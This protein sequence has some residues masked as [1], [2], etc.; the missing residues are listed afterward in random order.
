MSQ[1]VG[2]IGIGSPEMLDYLLHEEFRFVR[3]DKVRLSIPKL[4]RVGGLFLASVFGDYPK[5]IH[6]RIVADQHF[7]KFIA[8]PECLLE[9]YLDLMHE[10]EQFPRRLTGFYLDSPRKSSFVL[11]VDATKPNDLIDYWNLRAAGYIVL[12]IATQV[13][14]QPEILAHVA[15]FVDKNA[16]AEPMRNYMQAV[17]FMGARSIAHARV[18]EFLRTLELPPSD[19]AGRPR[20]ALALTYPRLWD[21]WA[22]DMADEGPQLPFGASQEAPV[23]NE[24]LEVEVNSVKPKFL[25]EDVM[26]GGQRYAN[27]VEVRVYKSTDPIAEV[28]PEGPRS[29]TQAFGSSALFSEWRLSKNGA[30]FFGAWSRDQVRI[31]GPNAEALMLSWLEHHGWKAELSP[32]G[33][34]AKQMLKQLNG[35]GGLHILCRQRLIELLHDVNKTGWMADATFRGRI[36]ELLRRENLRWSA[37]EYIQELASAGIIRLGIETQCLTCMRRNWYALDQL[38]Y[39]VGCSHC[40]AEFP[41]PA[42]DVD[43]LSWSY[44]TQGPFA[45]PDQAAGAYAVLL[46]LQF[47]QGDWGNGTSPLLSYSAQRGDKKMEADLTLLFRENRYSRADRISVIHAECKS[48]HSFESKDVQRMRA[49]GSHFPGAYLVFSKLGAY[50]DKERALIVPTAEK[51]RAQRFRSRQGNPVIVLSGVELFSWRGWPR[52]WEGKE[53]YKK[54][55][56][57][58]SRDRSLAMLADVTQQLHLK[59]KPYHEWRDE[60]LKARVATA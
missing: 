37:E 3:S 41:L 44:K 14:G 5:A 29:L 10:N 45:L 20:Y 39:R 50:S 53:P 30:V 19:V 13:M 15:K 11:L 55:Y 27:E 23:Q 47:L 4:G 58:C 60:K 35:V 1:G 46:T 49:L 31:K 6:S 9:S 59:L 18:A 33:R 34:I 42:G 7:A 38:K 12:P 32:S 51:E 28:I 56:E 57:L 26:Y 22:R 40:L 21:E 54:A 36:H 52:C 2:K 24:M 16:Y 25:P 8:Q 43:K 17:G 48:F